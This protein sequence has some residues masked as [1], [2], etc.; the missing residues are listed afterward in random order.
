MTDEK[1]LVASIVERFHTVGTARSRAMFGGYGIYVDECMVG[2]VADST[3]YL[4]ADKALAEE[5]RQLGL[6]HFTY[7]KDG[8]PYAMSYCQAPAEIFEDL[9]SLINWVEKSLRVARL[10]KASKRK[11]R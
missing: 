3:L 9:A 6:P 1:A 4:K 11:R 5:Y 7:F 8:K 10:A 2:L